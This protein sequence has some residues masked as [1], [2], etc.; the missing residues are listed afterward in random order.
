[1]PQTVNLPVTAGGHLDI[2]KKK[3]KVLKCPNC[4]SKKISPEAGF[5]T[6]YKYHCPDCDYVGPLV[7]EED[8]EDTEKEG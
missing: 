5:V 3:D 4:G 6:G 7:V 1:M 2:M 8:V